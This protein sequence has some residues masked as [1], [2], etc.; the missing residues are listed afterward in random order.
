M[1]RESCPENLIQSRAKRQTG[2]HGS[3][4]RPGRTPR[5]EYRKKQQLSVLR[6]LPVDYCRSDVA[7]R[8]F[9]LRAGGA[10]SDFGFER[11]NRLGKNLNKLCEISFAKSVVRT[12]YKCIISLVQDKLHFRRQKADIRGGCF[13]SRRSRVAPVCAEDAYK[14]LKNSPRLCFLRILRFVDGHCCPVYLV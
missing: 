4:C 6:L 5:T 13:A 3:L 8:M 10:K 9:P 12:R 7:G 14:D 11:S 1:C 2:C